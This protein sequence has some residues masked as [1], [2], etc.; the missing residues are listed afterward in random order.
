MYFY[1][2]LHFNQKVNPMISSEI[3]VSVESKALA[4]RSTWEEEIEIP[5]LDSSGRVFGLLHFVVFD[6]VFPFC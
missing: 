6:C 2:I 1:I 5:S 3:T 4:L